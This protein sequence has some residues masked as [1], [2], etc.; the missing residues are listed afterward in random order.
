MLTDDLEY[1]FTEYMGESLIPGFP[2][3]REQFRLQVED[4]LSRVYQLGLDAGNCR[5]A[6][7]MQLVDEAVGFGNKTPDCCQQGE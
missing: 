7:L 1:A 3:R 2:R 5:P 4:F 6:E